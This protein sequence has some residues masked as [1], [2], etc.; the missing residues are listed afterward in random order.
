MKKSSL[1]LLALLAFFLSKADSCH[2]NPVTITYT[3]RW[4]YDCSTYKVPAS[5][6]YGY[7]SGTTYMSL[8]SLV[9]TT[10][11]RNQSFTVTGKT[12]KLSMTSRL[13]VRGFYNSP[14]QYGPAA[15][16]PM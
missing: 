11:G 4:T 14:A 12:T 15:L 7:L 6:D 8:G 2:N 1:V 16:W 13:Y 3:M 9:V 10:C 5:F